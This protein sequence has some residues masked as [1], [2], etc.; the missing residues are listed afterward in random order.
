[1]AE[2]KAPEVIQ[3]GLV[4]VLDDLRV[5]PGAS[6][7]FFGEF[8]FVVSVVGIVGHEDHVSAVSGDAGIYLGIGWDID[9]LRQPF[10]LNLGIG[11]KRE[12]RKYQNQK[13]NFQGQSYMHGIL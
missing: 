6:L 9:I 2:A 7:I 13:Y 8:Q 10:S 11:V 4:D 1:M 3:P 5:F 12:N